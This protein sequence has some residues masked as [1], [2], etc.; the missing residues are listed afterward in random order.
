[1]QR[2]VQIEPGDAPSRAA[3]PARLLP[4]DE[5]GGAAVALHQ[6]R[7][8]DAD[9]ARVPALRGEHEG[10]VLR[11]QRSLRQLDR[12]VQ[13]ALVERLTA[14]VQRL[15]L[16]GDAGRLRRVVGEEQAQAV[17]RVADP[18]GGIEPR[19]QNEPHVPR[20]QRPARE[21]RGLDQGAQPRPARL[22]QHLQAVAHENAVLAHEGHDVGHG[23]ERHVVQEMERHVGRQSEGRHQRLGE[24]EGDPGAAQV[25]VLG[26]AIGAPRIEHCR[27]GGEGVPGE[28][29]IGDD[30]VASRGARRAHR[31]QRPD[32]AVAGD[33]EARAHPLRLRQARGPEV[34]TVAQPVRHERVHRGA[35]AREHPRE[36]RRRA[37]AIHVVVAVHEDGDPAAHRGRHQRDGRAHVRPG[38]RV[39]QAL[40]LGPQERFRELRGGEAALH[41]DGRERLGD[42]EIGGERGDEL[43][44]GP[45]RERPAGGDHSLAYS[46]TPQA[47]Q[48]SIDAPRAISARRCVGTAVK[49]CP[50]ASPWRG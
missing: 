24:L 21:P 27:G 50:Q 39:A 37:L 16:A 35:G 32:A 31:L 42:S 13:D 6:P 10:V 18:A 12:L 5:E 30:H 3:P 22:G 17:P 9:D 41:Q 11:A 34:V 43:R 48:P 19:R 46:S 20:P 23:R 45:V 33:D 8:D 36:Q 38:E 14:R 44:V 7:R 15:E 4:G 26:G 40:E 1:M 28:V 25:L 29:M 49:Q 47:S 2:L